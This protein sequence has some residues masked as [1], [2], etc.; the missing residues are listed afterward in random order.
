MEIPVPIPNTE[1]KH[2][3]ADCSLLGE[4]RKL[5]LNYEKQKE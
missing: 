5:P 3:W 1:V 2:C 4:S